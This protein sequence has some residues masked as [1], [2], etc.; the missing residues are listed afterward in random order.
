MLDALA[1]VVLDKNREIH[2]LHGRIEG[3]PRD[4]WILI[5]FGDIIVHIFSPD[6]RDY[7]NLEDVWQGANTLLHVQ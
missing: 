4:G 7:Y 2:R 1:K 6:Q 5:D 3:L